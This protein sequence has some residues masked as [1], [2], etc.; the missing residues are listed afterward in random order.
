MNT[1]SK[2]YVA[3][4][5]G[6]VG[7]ALMRKL[8][9]DGYINIITK[10]LQELDLRNQAAVNNFF[11][12]EK[13]EYVFLA[14]ARVGGIIANNT[15]RAE[16]IYDN[17]MIAANVIHAAYQHGVKKLLNLGSSC[18][19]PKNAP[20]PL[21]ESY[22]LSG[23]LE[24]TNEPYALAKIAAIKLC[25]AYNMQYGT[26][27]ISAMPT[28]LYGPNDNF[29]LETSHVLPALMR[30]FHEAK[31]AQALSVT[32]WGTGA[33]LREF[34]YVDDLADA[35]LMLMQKYNVSDVGECINIG[36]GVDVTI[37]ELAQAIK[38]IV[39]YE[40]EIVFDASKPDGTGRKLLDVSKIE[41]LGWRYQIDLEMGIKRAYDWYV[42]KL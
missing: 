6:L 20:Q 29:N 11:A 19:Y 7:S 36:T 5:M 18:I 33:P 31:I 28:N 40:G 42:S 4:H 3:G 39:G 25:D 15:Y 10:T 1:S 2:I 21:K 34:L 35:V 23:I 8:H 37:A 32:V 9:A 24:S 26:N 30:K 16:F 41:A 38:R 13:P 17:L 14:A 22:L 27:F 12:Y